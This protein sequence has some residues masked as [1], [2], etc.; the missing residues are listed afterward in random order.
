MR[1]NPYT[2]KHEEAEV[3]SRAGRLH[4]DAH[5]APKEVWI[6]PLTSKPIRGLLLAQVEGDTCRRVG[7]VLRLFNEML[8]PEDDELRMVSIV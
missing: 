3:H 4:A 1:L 2:G 5:E 6:L 8:S 7:L